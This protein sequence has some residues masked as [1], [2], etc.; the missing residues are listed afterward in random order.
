[1]DSDHLKIGIKILTEGTNIII[2]H[3]GAF[4]YLGGKMQYKR[5]S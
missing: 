1:M 2:L 4:Q 3:I 5:G